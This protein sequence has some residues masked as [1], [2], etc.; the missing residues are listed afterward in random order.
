MRL[1]LNTRSHG[2][3]TSVVLH[4]GLGNQL[5]QYF[6][7]SMEAA[8]VSASELRVITD[9][10]A[11]YEGSRAL[12]IENL[13][14]AVG[15]FPRV[16]LM[17]SDILLR[18]R[19]P[20]IVNRLVG[21]ELIMRIPIYG[22]VLDGYFQE[23]RFFRAYPTELL[24]SSLTTWRNILSEQGHLQP[25]QRRSV[26]HIRLT[27]FFKSSLDAKGFVKQKLAQLSEATDLVTD[28]EEIVMDALATFSFP[29]DVRLQR[30]STFT[31]W[32]VFA[33]F[34]TYE[35]IETNGSSLAFWAAVLAQTQ[36]RSSNAKHVSIWQYITANSPR[37]L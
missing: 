10:I 31:A 21:R 14:N 25:K 9:F 5:F 37:H 34:S 6:I 32:E 29:F 8:S 27:D 35:C 7:A 3:A 15:F 2:A 26:M 30:T 12:E 13:I 4:G 28:Q 18:A 24:N 23:L 17:S 33:L 19:L 11:Q 22:T 1:Q 20:K 36:F 16:I